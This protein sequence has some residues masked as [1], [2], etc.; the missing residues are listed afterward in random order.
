MVG[1]DA[2]PG[3][4]VV[5]KLERHLVVLHL[6]ETD[7]LPALETRRVGQESLDDE[8]AA[9]GQMAVDVTEAAEL[10][11]LGEESEEGAEGDKDEGEL[12]FHISELRH[13]AHRDGYAIAARLGPQF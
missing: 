2:L 1:I 12:A 13:V 5:R 9:S 4:V 11:F 7:S 6:L 8:Q 10:L 3:Q